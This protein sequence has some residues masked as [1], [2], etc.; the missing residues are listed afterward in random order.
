MNTTPRG[1]GVVITSSHNARHHSGSVGYALTV[2]PREALVLG[3]IFAAIAMG[4][5]TVQVVIYSTRF[6][7]ERK[8]AVVVANIVFL[9]NLISLAFLGEGVFHCLIVEFSGGVVN[10]LTVPQRY[11]LVMLPGAL[12]R[13]IVSD[14]LAIVAASMLDSRL[15]GP[16][17]HLLTA[18]HLGLMGFMVHI[19]Y[20][21]YGSN[22]TFGKIYPPLLKVYNSLSLVTECV[23]CILFCSAVFRDRL[24]RHSGKHSDMGQ[25]TH[26]IIL[27]Y[28]LKLFWY[29]A[30]ASGMWSKST[31][32][33]ACFG[34]PLGA[35]CNITFLALLHACPSRLTPTLLLTGLQDWPRQS[36]SAA[37]VVT[38]RDVA[39][40]SCHDGPLELQH[41]ERLDRLFPEEEESRSYPSAGDVPTVKRVKRVRVQEPKG[42]T[43]HG[44]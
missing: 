35:V 36:V 29:I 38:T 11:T 31:F 43:R 1:S 21:S 26:H 18:S 23:G 5:A 12:S 15:I 7:K 30:F 37:S 17:F 25:M 34:I 22:S 3:L 41:L 14:L 27:A 6:Y 24:A 19:I 39:T 33:T 13:T 44:A 9:Y 10:R 4:I 16:V 42:T 40:E 20:N 2:P 8:I 32:V 28:C